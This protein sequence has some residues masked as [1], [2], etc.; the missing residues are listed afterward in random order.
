MAKKTEKNKFKK[1][2]VHNYRLVISSEDTWEEKFSLRLNRLNVFVVLSIS[3]IL[4]IAITTLIISFTPIREYIPGYESPELRKNAQNLIF[5]TDSLEN[6]VK[7]NQ[8]YIDNL[9]LILSGEIDSIELGAP[10]ERVDTIDN[11][12]NDYHYANFANSK[13]DSIFRAEI[14]M[15]DRY[16]LFGKKKKSNFILVAPISGILSQKYDP[17]NKHFAVDVA[18]S[19]GTPVKAVADGTVIFSEWTSTTG[20]VLIIEHKNDLISVYKHCSSST[21]AQGD[22]IESGEVIAVS[23]SSGE[24]STGPHL[25]FELWYNG[26]PVNPSDYINFEL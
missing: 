2:L 21:K 12:K 18:V 26:F 23:G 17:K 8:A 20:N 11:H 19:K 16:N 5:K 24:L 9:A 6:I 15:E 1:K 14:E 4:L 3:S 10:V 13:E 7:R 22:F 25:H